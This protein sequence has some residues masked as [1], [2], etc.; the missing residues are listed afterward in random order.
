MDTRSP[1]VWLHIDTCTWTKFKGPDALSWCPKENDID[2]EPHDDSLLDEIALFYGDYRP[3][4]QQGNKIQNGTLAFQKPR[5]W[6]LWKSKNLPLWGF[7]STS[8]TLILSQ[9]CKTYVLKKVTKYFAKVGWLFK[10]TKSG[11]PL[12]V[13]F[14]QSKGSE[15]MTQAHELLGH[16]GEK[17]T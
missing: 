5:Y 7:T 12:I 16:H 13:I 6:K 2:V 3:T 14:D 10:Q 11:H 9:L 4:L 15:L 17:A 8:L 1:P